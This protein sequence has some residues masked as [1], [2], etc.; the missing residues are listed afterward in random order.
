M[1][2][3][4]IRPVRASLAVKEIDQLRLDFFEP[5]LRA[6]G[7]P[8]EHVCARAY[9]AYCIM[10]GNSILNRSLGSGLSEED[11]LSQAKLVLGD[12]D[13]AHPIP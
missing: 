6:Q 13:A 12:L 9:V 2:I 5:M 1:R 8:E 11:Y 10:M 7:L 4:A 3:N